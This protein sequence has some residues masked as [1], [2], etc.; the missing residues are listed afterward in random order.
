MVVMVRS[1]KEIDRKAIRR[2][3]RPTTVRVRASAQR[4]RER[5][6]RTCVSA[7]A[8][9]KCTRGYNV[10]KLG[11]LLARMTAPRVCGSSGAID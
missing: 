2:R 1:E 5:K 10:V 9:A 11:K 6:R 4:E 8:C 7:E 3:S